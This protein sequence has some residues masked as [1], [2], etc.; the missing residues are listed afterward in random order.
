MKAMARARAKPVRRLR[1]SEVK[2]AAPDIGAQQ[3]HTDAIAYVKI[4]EPNFEPPLNRRFL[5][6]DPCAGL[7]DAGDERLE[8]FSH[9]RRR[10]V[11]YDRR[12]V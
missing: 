10:Y 9:A 7:V 5:K 12:F 4:V 1:P 6:A 3:P 2:K 8:T 11:W